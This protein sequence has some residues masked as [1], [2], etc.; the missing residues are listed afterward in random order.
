MQ[1]DSFTAGGPSGGAGGH[2]ALMVEDDRVDQ[3]CH[4]RALLR[5]GHFAGVIACATADD[6][7]DWLAVRDRPPADVILLDLHLPG[8]TGFEF[9]EA[10]RA[11]AGPE[12]S[13]A[14]VILMAS[15]LSPAEQR[16]ADQDPT[17]DAM[18]PKPLNPAELSALMQHRTMIPDGHS[19]PLQAALRPC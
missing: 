2:Y 7:L 11:R 5:T 3:L 19:A 4:R 14:L 18:L 13:R 10:A 9:L 15:G 12:L 8:R 17:I 6:A 1:Q 16:Q